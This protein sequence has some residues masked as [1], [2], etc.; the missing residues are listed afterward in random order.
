MESIEG[1]R[2]HAEAEHLREGGNLEEAM[3]T[4]KKAQMTYVKENDLLGVAEALAS[5]VLI[6]RHLGER[7]NK[8][9]CLMFAE[10]A[11]KLSVEM[12]EKSGSK[13]ALALPYHTL[14]KVLEDME[15]WE[16]A[17]NAQKKALEV[18]ENNPPEKHN[19]PAYVNEMKIHWL[20]D[21]YM[22]G[23]KE[24]TAELDEVLIALEADAAETKY[25]RDVW[26]S[27]GF[28][29]KASILKN[30]NPDEALKAFTRAGE[31]IGAN[32]DLKLRKKQWNSRAAE[33]GLEM[34]A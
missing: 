28:M 10:M 2:I 15:K 19:R 1:R 30:D 20:A 22:C 21:R 16:E 12:A 14:G 5:E 9:E 34:I 3:A 6:W 11:A 23:E 17:K 4:I 29:S 7:E 25:N 31:I 26:L 18:M 27:G 24:V 8:S 33:F 32:I 13:E